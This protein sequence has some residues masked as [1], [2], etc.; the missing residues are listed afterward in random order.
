M[1]FTVSSSALLK[2][3][4]TVSGAI[5]NNA[6]LP[7]LSDFL[8]RVENSVLTISA[9]DLETSMV[10]ELVVNAD[11]DGAVAV[12]SKILLEVLKALPEQPLM[13]RVDTNTFAIELQTLNGKYKLSGEDGD[14]FPR[15]PEASTESSVS[16]SALTLSTAINR[17][18]F[19]VSTDELRPAMTG[20]LFVLESNAVTFVATDAHRLVKYTVNGLDLSNETT[21]FIV[22][23]KALN[24]LKSTLPTSDV[25]VNLSFDRLNAYFSFNEIRLVCRLIDARFPDYASVIPSNNNNLLTLNR[26]GFQNS[27][28]RIS[29]FSNKTTHQI[30]LRIKGT[31][32]TLNAQDLDYAN[33][34]SEIMDCEFE[35]EDMDIAFNGRFLSDV[36]ANLSTEEVQLSMSTPNRAVLVTPTES[37]ENE[38][39]VMLVMPIMLNNY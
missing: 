28:R 4:Q 30:V 11:S 25:E 35:G 1:Q 18:L 32:L 36:M 9:T 33:E 14:D 15:I 7:I 6:T 8:F 31:Q 10:A 26:A 27:V 34:A 12:P 21:Q 19:A 39:I 29:I 5:G 24:L 16:L 22:P 20:V 2:Q 13:F 38:E 23:R 17:T 37:S 3:L